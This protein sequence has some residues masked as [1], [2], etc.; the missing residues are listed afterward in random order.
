MLRVKI[1]AKGARTSFSRTYMRSKEFLEWKNLLTHQVFAN[2]AEN[3][4]VNPTKASHETLIQIP[5]ALVSSIMSSPPSSK[6]RGVMEL[7]TMRAPLAFM[8]RKEGCDALTTIPVRLKM[9]HPRHA[10]TERATIPKQTK[11]IY[12]RFPSKLWPT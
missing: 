2:K 7:A 10:R 11:P 8:M 6:D 4:T 9:V 12:L 1:T 5:M 3:M